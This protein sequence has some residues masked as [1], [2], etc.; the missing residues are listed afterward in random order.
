MRAAFYEAQG[1]AADVMQVGHLPDPQPGAGESLQTKPLKQV[2][3][4]ERCW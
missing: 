1:A 3:H 2:T 4:P